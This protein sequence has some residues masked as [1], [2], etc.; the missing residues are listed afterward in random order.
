MPKS[1]HAERTML[2]GFLQLLSI[3]RRYR[4]LV[5]IVTGTVAAGVV[6]F[7]VVSLRLPPERS[8]LPNRYTADA[9]VLVQRGMG[10]SLSASILAALGIQSQP[11]DTAAGFSMGSLVLS[12]LESRTFL[13]KIIEEFNIVERY[14]INDMVKTKSRELLLRKSSFTYTPANASVTISFTDLD[15]VFASEVTNR[16]VFL[17]GEWFAQNINNSNQ[18]QK[19][20]LEEKIKEVKSG[21]DSLEGRLKNLQKKYGVLGAQDLGT[22]QASALAALRSQLILKEIEIKNYS[23]ISAIEDPKLLQLKEER[24]NIIDLITQTQ[25][26]IPDVEGGEA[27]PTSLPDIQIQFNR[28]N[29]EL[30]IQREIY[31]TLSHQ[32]E[33]LKL[34]SEPESAFQIMELAEVPDSKSGPS[35]GAIAAV[36]TVVAFVVSVLFA[37]FL[38]SLSQI[39]KAR[40]AR[41]ADG[42]GR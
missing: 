13:D 22:S 35:R 1:Q 6:A 37:F 40:E 25:R 16:M 11:T 36:A 4:W 8:P 21:V 19:Q 20:L 31:N 18:R 32:Y 38:N 17:L 3:L 7:C 12:V 27:D 26:G 33:V 24:Q 42:M 28:L 15:P 39:R 5:I 30:N 34:T 41:P 29:L 10:D 23:G 2:E 9:V 14:R